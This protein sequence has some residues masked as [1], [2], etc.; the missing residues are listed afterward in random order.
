MGIVQVKNNQKKLKKTCKTT[1]RREKC[2]DEYISIEKGH[3]RIEKRKA[4]VYNPS[5]MMELEWQKCVKSFIVIEKNVKKKD[6]KAK[7]W[8]GS[9]ETSYFICT[10]KISAREGLGYI[11]KHW[12]IENSNNYVKDVS[13]GEDGSRIRKN[14]RIIATIRSFALNILRQFPHESVKGQLFLNALSSSFL[15]QSLISLSFP[16][17]S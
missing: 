8:I 14:P 4:I 13:M 5:A 1:Y 11:R 6:T 2:E 9:Q 10:E 3:G 17:N 12:A 16:S 15:L 7:K